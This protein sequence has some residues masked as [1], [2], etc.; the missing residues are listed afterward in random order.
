VVVDIATGG[1]EDKHVLVTNGLKDFNVD[2][3]I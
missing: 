3:P 2:P 1:L